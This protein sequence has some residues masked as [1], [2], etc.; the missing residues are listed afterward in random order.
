MIPAVG[1][2]SGNEVEV[3]SASRGKDGGGRGR[4]SKFEDVRRSHLNLCSGFDRR[5]RYFAI[6]YDN[7][8]IAIWDMVTKS[9]ATSIQDE[10]CRAIA[11]VDWGRQSRRLLTTRRDVCG[12]ATLWRFDG[13]TQ[14]MPPRGEIDT[15][16]ERPPHH[17]RWPRKDVSYLSA[18]EEKAS[19]SADV[20]H[21][22][23]ARF[24][25][26]RTDVC[27][28][29]PRTQCPRVVLFSKNDVPLRRISVTRAS[30]REKT[31]TRWYD[32]V[33]TFSRRNANVLFVSTGGSTRDHVRDTLLYCDVSSIVRS[34]SS[35]STPSRDT[36]VAKTC[37]GIQLGNA[38]IVDVVTS[39]SND[40]ILMTCT[41][42]SMYLYRADIAA[43]ASTPTH[44]HMHTAVRDV[45]CTLLHRFV[46][47]VNRQ[48][49]LSGRFSGDGEYVA[50]TG[51][52]DGAVVVWNTAGRVMRKL[53]RGSSRCVRIDWHPRRPT[54]AAS[55]ATGHVLLYTKQFKP[56]WTA[57]A[58]TFVPVEAN[59]VYV[60]REDE[61]DIWDENGLIEREHHCDLRSPQSRKSR[62][63]NA[64][65]DRVLDIMNRVHVFSS[66][67]E[68]ED[69]SFPVTLD[70][71]IGVEDE[72]EEEEEED[73]EDMVNDGEVVMTDEKYEDAI[74]LDKTASA[75][76]A[77]SKTLSQRERSKRDADGL[78]VGARISV[79]WPGESTWF[80]GHVADVNESTRTYKIVFDD[81]DVIEY[82]NFK[83]Q[84][85]W[86]VLKGQT[87]QKRKRRKQGGERPSANKNT[88]RVSGYNLFTREAGVPFKD[89][90][91][92][93]RGLSDSE[94]RGWNK[95]ASKNVDGA[96]V[97]PQKKKKKKAG[98]V[99]GYNLF[100]REAGVPFKEAG[101]AWRGLSDAERADWNAKASKSV[102]STVMGHHQTTKKRKNKKT[103]KSMTE[104]RDS[105]RST[106]PVVT[107]ASSMRNVSPAHTMMRR[108]VV[109]PANSMIRSPSPMTASLPS[110][111]R[112]Q[113][114]KPTDPR[115]QQL[116]QMDPR[117]QQLKPMDPRLQQLKPTDPRLQKPKPTDPRLQKLNPTD[118]R[119]QKPK[120]TDPRLQKPK[121]TDP[122]LQKP[123]PTD[124]RLQQRNRCI[125][126]NRSTPS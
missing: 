11:S 119:Q 75:P 6:G 22:R 58:P 35:S 126:T 114:P 17:E 20:V 1:S 89:A 60:E 61:F 64:R 29:C 47:T 46:D 3:A 53:P 23:I 112:L 78:D 48:A 51:S 12:E 10:R 104:T 27:V 88:G 44:Q 74:V 111:P 109:S 63:S 32:P 30:H 73:E 16:P 57:F 81:G 124:P 117:L 43:V 120:P 116:K 56:Q 80:E 2:S 38:R 87:S 82:E 25:P 15:M 19:S 62:S 37:Q 40:L 97:M 31:V 52:I 108:P 36:I 101:A 66:D 8:V 98:R 59:T 45:T 71:A 90:G 26:K 105:S 4:K 123:K 49:W 85:T 115:L 95:K 33:A 92:A 9:M 50:A 113:K 77:E 67:D 13:A 103:T 107:P 42:R 106:R 5:G 18:H 21:V 72:E 96:A 118:P 76:R 125:R 94:R 28:L 41:D 68:D 24:H 93:W 100:M 54:I 69:F 79:Y 84:E 39:R 83:T 65:T 99:S 70:R 7:G 86:M 91:A 110:D 14:T 102:G 121:P 34:T 55:T 122:R